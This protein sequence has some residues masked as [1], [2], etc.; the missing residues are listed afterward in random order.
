MD[1]STE[2][3]L[4]AA[5]LIMVRELLNITPEQM[6]Q[7]MKISTETLMEIEQGKKALPPDCLD[8]LVSATNINA[9]WLLKG[10]TLPNEFYKNYSTLCKYLEVPEVFADI[11]DKLQTCKILFKDPIKEMIYQGDKNEGDG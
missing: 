11:V 8:A 5:R 10:R 9:K 1:V 6:A 4:I 7:I 3:I 2:I